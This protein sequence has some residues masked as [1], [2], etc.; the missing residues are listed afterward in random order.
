MSNE[1]DELAR[2]DL[3]AW[4]V[5]PA[6]AEDRA[7][8]LARALTPAIPARRSRVGW[9]IAAFAIANGVL[10]AIVL[11]VISR[12][13]PAP[14]VTVRP[15]GDGQTTELLRHLDDEQRELSAKI[16]ELQ[17]MRASVELL[18]A[19]VRECELKRDRTEP[20]PSPAV[21][22]APTPAPTPPLAPLDT[23]SC[24]EV[25]CVL[26]NYE[27]PCC[28]KYRH[29]GPPESL[30]RAAITT[31]VS[32]VKAEVLACGQRSTAKGTVK[33]HVRVGPS[34]HVTN[35][36]INSTPDAGLG[37]CVAGAVTKA[38]FESTVQGGSFSYPFVF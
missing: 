33:V 22:P 26:S 21:A 29:D 2:I 9:T 1:D 37:A 19:Q 12:P 4:R 30:D 3:H 15:A 18:E 17:R 23:G 13:R 36:E 38:T 25:S 24:D 11:I 5:P 27:G 8:I 20:R 10:A 35:V 31:G 16:A 7:R 6:D 34:G 32:G 28:I 14:T